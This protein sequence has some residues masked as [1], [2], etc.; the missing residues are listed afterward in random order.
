MRVPGLVVPPLTPFR[1]GG[2]AVDYAALRRQIDYIVRTAPSATIGAACVET[3]EYHYLSHAERIELIERTV[4]FVDHRA[5]VMVGVSHPN[6]R[7]AVELAQLAERLG[8]EA[9]QALAPLRPFGGPPSLDDLLAYYGTILAGTSLPLCVYH[10]PGPGAEVPPA[11]MVR[12]A[13]LERVRYFKESSRDLRRIGLLIEEIDLAG[14]ARYFTTMEPLLATLLLGGSGAAMPP[15][16][17][18]L[19][20]PVL[21][22]FVAGDLEAARQRAAVFRLFPSKWIGRGLVAVMKAAMRVAG[23]D[24]GD[25]HP[26]YQPLTPEECRELERHLVRHEIAADGR[27]EARAH[28]QATVDRGREAH[29]AGGRAEVPGDRRADVH[30][31]RGRVGQPHRV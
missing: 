22:A 14:H 16:G 27:E 15:P 19:A 5:P 2:S 10:N 26:P 11:W 3:Q 20:Q 17:C 23:V 4:E 28:H 9:V 13:Q 12:L 8:A 31:G 25:P 6:P 18:A 1:G 7:V 24:V 30:G 21:D 29:P